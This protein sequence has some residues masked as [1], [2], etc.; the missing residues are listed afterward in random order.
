MENASKALLIAGGV[1]LAI[2]ILSVM[3]YSYV[4][5]QSL[6]RAKAEVLKAEEL[7]AFNREFESYNKKSMYGTDI[8]SVVNKANSYN[9]KY[10]MDLITIYIQIKENMN[11]IVYQYEFI[12][13]EWESNIISDDSVLEPK[14]YTNKTINSNNIFNQ[15]EKWNERYELKYDNDN[16][17]LKAYKTK[18]TAFSLLKRS[19]FSCESIIYNQ[20]SGQVES[21]SFIQK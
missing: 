15:E 5:M 21:M 18:T 14:S 1:L 16:G 8:V 20:I 2:I 19:S 13:G 11:T 3:I 12:N 7:A 10:D 6:E 9:K 17:R 4:H